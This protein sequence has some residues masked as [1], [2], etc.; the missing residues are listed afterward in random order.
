MAATKSGCSVG[1]PQKD[2][3]E[4]AKGK[5]ETAFPAED[6]VDAKE[7]TMELPECTHIYNNYH[8]AARKDSGGLFVDTL[9]P[10]CYTEGVNVTFLPQGRILSAGEPRFIFKL[11]AVIFRICDWWRCFFIK[12]K[13]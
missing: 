9:G 11:S 10:I 7:I 12:M 3:L 6:F 8:R 5:A 2:T 13:E 4:E 1:N